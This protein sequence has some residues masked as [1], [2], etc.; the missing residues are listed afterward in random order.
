MNPDHAPKQAGT[1]AEKHA[2]TYYFVKSDIHEE[3]RFER[4]QQAAVL[5][6]ALLKAGLTVSIRKGS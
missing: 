3:V 1:N 5:A 4:L 6:R 2:P